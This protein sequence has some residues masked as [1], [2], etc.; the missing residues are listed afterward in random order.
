MG[1]MIFELEKRLFDLY[2]HVEGKEDL[3]S[4]WEEAEKKMD[5]VILRKKL[6]PRPMRI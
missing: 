4:M 5:E 2:E 1:D 6:P 3:F